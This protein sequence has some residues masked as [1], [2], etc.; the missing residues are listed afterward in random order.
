VFDADVEN[1]KLSN[2]RVFAEMPKPSM[3]DGTRADVANLLLRRLGDPNENGVRCYSPA[4]ELI[5]KIHL[6]ETAANVCLGRQQRNRLYIC[7][8]TPLYALYTG[9]QGAMKP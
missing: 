5:E 1:D 2:S 7:G 9:A 6:P 3:T 4:G 8:S